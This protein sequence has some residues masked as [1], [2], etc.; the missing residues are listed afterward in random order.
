MPDIKVFYF[1]ARGRAE[2][3]RLVLS[4]AGQD[5]DDVR[6]SREEW[7][8]YKEVA[9]FGQAPFAEYKGKKYGQ[10]GAIASFF[11]DEF[12]L[13]GKTNLD[14]VRIDE[15]I[16]LSNDLLQLRMKV[17]FEQDETKKAELD[18]KLIEEDLPK[19]FGYFQRLLQENSPNGVFVGRE[20]TL[21]DLYVYDQMFQLNKIRNY[22]AAEQF[23]DLKALK[24]RVESNPRL[25]TY[26]ANR[27]DTAM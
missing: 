19:Y 2:I 24:D 25:K 5:F 9:P 16:G 18:T 20:L 26:L 14:H 17:H 22:D 7:P 23:A 1:D 11:A 4:L 15:V 13:Y 3:I 21:A 27:K 10:S 8:K 12:S 6:F